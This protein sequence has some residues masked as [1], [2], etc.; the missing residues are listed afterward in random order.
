MIIKYWDIIKKQ[1][2]AKKIEEYLT[3]R[4]IMG[5]HKILDFSMEKYIKCHIRFMSDITEAKMLLPWMKTEYIYDNQL[6]EEISKLLEQY[7]DVIG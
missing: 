7:S 4:Q 3:I 5:L 1:E 6:K 2:F